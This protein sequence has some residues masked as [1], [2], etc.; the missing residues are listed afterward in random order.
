M[1]LLLCK[2]RDE[3]LSIEQRSNI[4]VL[5]VVTL[6]VD[7]MVRIPHDTQA[8]TDVKMFKVIHYYVHIYLHICKFVI[9]STS[10]STHRKS[11]HKTCWNNR[12]F[13]MSSSHVFPRLHG[14]IIQ[15]SQVCSFFNFLTGFQCQSGHCARQ[16]IGVQP[17]LSEQCC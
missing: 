6:F 16:I 2:Y 8:Y 5:V 9:K 4:I 13:C 17:K 12:A 11:Q 10:I 15:I 7:I 1:S 14:E 3:Q